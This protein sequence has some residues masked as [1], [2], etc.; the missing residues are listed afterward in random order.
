MRKLNVCPFCGSTSRAD[1]VKVVKYSGIFC[2]K[3]ER[4]GAHS[5]NA[6]T[7]DEAVSKWNHRE[8]LTALKNRIIRLQ[9]RII[10]KV[11]GEVYDGVNELLE[12]RVWKDDL[13]EVLRN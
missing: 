4:C 13:Y 7:E 10:Q 12:D 3:C 6:N 5:G 9:S 2:V 8:Q 11:N 1:M